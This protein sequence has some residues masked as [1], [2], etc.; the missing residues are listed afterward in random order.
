MIKNQKQ[1]AVV[2]KEIDD[3][4]ALILEMDEVSAKQKLDLKQ[5]LQYNVWKGRIE[6]LIIEIEEYKILT[7]PE[8]RTLEIGSENLAKA[9]VSFRIASGMTQSDLADKLE[10]Q[11]QQIQRY[12]QNDYLTASFERIIQILKTLEIEVILKKEF[13]KEAKVVDFARF[14]IPDSCKNNLEDN[15]RKVANRNQLLKV[16]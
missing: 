5:Q 11:E 12:E 14:L 13:S 1:A 3:L 4:R 15:V 2:R 7:S 16:G 9:I 8:L 6:D 10:I